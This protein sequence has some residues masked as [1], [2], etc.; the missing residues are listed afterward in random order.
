MFLYTSEEE[1]AR[2]SVRAQ[3]SVLELLRDQGKLSIGASL[4]VSPLLAP[5][6][7]SRHLGQCSLHDPEVATILQGAAPCNTEAVSITVFDLMHGVQE[8]QTCFIVEYAQVCPVCP[9][10]SDFPS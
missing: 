9:V 8:K 3:A 10:P 4:N 1:W 2:L 7:D 5:L 6:C